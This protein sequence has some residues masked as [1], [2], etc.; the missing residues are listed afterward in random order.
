MSDA[1]SD[2]VK[3]NFF[4]FQKRRQTLNTFVN[5]SADV[6]RLLH[7]FLDSETITESDAQITILRKIGHNIIAENWKEYCETFSKKLS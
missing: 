7:A 3:R 2:P 4:E 5:M 1:D 6:I